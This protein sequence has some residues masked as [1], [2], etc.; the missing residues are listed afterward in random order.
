MKELQGLLSG[1]KNI[2]M[3]KNKKKKVKSL[4]SKI[5]IIGLGYVGLPLA[6]EFSKKRKVIG[7]DVDKKRIRDLINGN[8]FTRE[9]SVDEIKNASNLEFSSNIDD[10]KKCKV[11][12]ITVPTPINKKK[13]LICLI[14]KMQQN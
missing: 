14:L 2:M 12:I 6:I 1:T 4:Q 3:F 9:T 11:F 7:F 10:I 13:N 5:A 8:D